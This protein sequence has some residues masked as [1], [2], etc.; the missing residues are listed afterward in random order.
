MVVIDGVTVELEPGA[1]SPF[2][3]D[4]STELGRLLLPYRNVSRRHGEFIIRAPGSVGRLQVVDRSTNGTW[5]MCRQKVPY[6]IP[7]HTPTEVPPGSVLRL[8]C[9]PVRNAH[10]QI[11]EDAQ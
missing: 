6:R 11:I 5:I 1:M 9:S 4:P 2:G 8:G 7:A 10:L 3:R